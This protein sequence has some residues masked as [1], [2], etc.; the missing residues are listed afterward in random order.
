MAKARSAKLYGVHVIEVN[1]SLPLSAPVEH[2]V[3][4]GG[5]VKLIILERIS[6]S[7]ILLAVAGALVVGGRTGFLYQLATAAQ[8]QLLL[9]A[10]HTFITSFVLLVV[11]WI[12]FF[13]H[14]TLL[15]VGLVG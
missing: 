15:A 8:E 1:R 4:H 6:K 3:E 10:D 11:E 9:S 13:N 2:L 7:A 5:F 12:G 14:Q